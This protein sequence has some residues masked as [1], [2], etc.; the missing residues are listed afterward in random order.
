M[1]W[2]DE[3]ASTYPVDVQIE[4][5]DRSGLLRDISQL[6]A[7]EKVNVLA[8]NTLS[9]KANNTADMQITIEISSIEWLSRILAKIDQLSNV[10]R[11]YRA[12]NH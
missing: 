6:L 8:I 1:N 10:I 11:A 5:Y 7:T 2:G 4:A 3:P 12:V 9:D